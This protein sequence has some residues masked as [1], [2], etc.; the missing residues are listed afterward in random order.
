MTMASQ[1]A[2]LPATAKPL[3]ASES[4][5]L[6]VSGLRLTTANL[7]DVVSGLPTS[8]TEGEDER[9]LRGQRLGRGAPLVEQQARAEPGPAEV[10]P[11]DRLRQGDPLGTAGRRIN[12]QVGAVEGEH[13]NP[14]SAIRRLS[15]S[16]TIAT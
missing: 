12:P 11:Q 10:L 16:G 8:G 9:C 2:C 3:L 14:L 1:P 4:L 13:H 6:Y 7:A 5:N 15:R